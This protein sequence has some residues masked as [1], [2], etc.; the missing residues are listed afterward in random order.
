MASSGTF[1]KH[2][3][4]QLN[5]RS[6]LLP[7]YECFPGISVPIPNKRPLRMVCPNYFSLSISWGSSPRFWC[8]SRGRGDPS[9]LRHGWNCPRSQSAAG[10]CLWAPPP[11]ARPAA[12][13]RSSRLRAAFRRGAAAMRQFRHHGSKSKA[14]SHARELP[15]HPPFS[16]HHQ[17]ST[18][19][20]H[21]TY[22]RGGKRRNSKPEWPN[23]WSNT[24]FGVCSCISSSW[25]TTNP[26]Q[27]AA[28][29][30]SNHWQPAPATTVK[31]RV[32]FLKGTSVPYFPLWL[33]GVTSLDPLSD[34]TH[35][36]GISELLKSNMLHHNKRSLGTLTMFKNILLLRH[37]RWPQRGQ[38]HAYVLKHPQIAHPRTETQQMQCNFRSIKSLS[39]KLLHLW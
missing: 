31:R 13:P 15:P 12:A 3:L 26:P 36:W 17:H 29:C 24:L 16:L 34:H 35:F 32:P 18:L 2:I 21:A 27:P 37:C 4:H 20:T 23:W 30:H 38:H 1:Y 9:L 8:P 22:D 6:Q 19:V 14:G 25:P 11:R 39:V 33:Y 10:G 7:I 5:K 28:V